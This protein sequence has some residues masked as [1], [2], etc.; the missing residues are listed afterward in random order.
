MVP[1]AALPAGSHLTE[2]QGVKHH[3]TAHAF[4]Q[5]AEAAPW[6]ILSQHQLEVKVKSM[7]HP[8]TSVKKTA[9]TIQSHLV[10]TL[11]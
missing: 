6:I 2:A 9:Q 5:A 4:P 8:P 7:A 11:Y 3:L 10:L 1:G